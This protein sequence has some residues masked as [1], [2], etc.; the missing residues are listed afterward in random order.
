MEHSLGRR[1]QRR[2]EA[3]GIQPR[4]NVK[5][6]KKKDRHSNVCPFLFIFIVPGAVLLSV[7]APLRRLRSAPPPTAQT[8]H[9]PRFGASGCRLRLRA[10]RP[11]EPGVLSN[12]P[13]SGE[14]LRLFS[15]A[16]A[17]PGTA[18]TRWFRKY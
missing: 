2:A 3:I 10:H 4:I 12:R 18:D 8:T 15:A 7:H 6:Q 9:C 17:S 16:G 11:E 1:A 5:F 13:L 14:A